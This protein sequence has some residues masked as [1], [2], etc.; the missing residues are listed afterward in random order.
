MLSQP[1]QVT[2]AVLTIKCVIEVFREYCRGGSHSR[3]FGASADQVLLVGAVFVG[4]AE[5]RPMNASKLSEYVGMPRATVIRKLGSLSRR[6]VIERDGGG[7]VL[8][9]ETLL[10]ER[11]KDAMVRA[12]KCLVD[13]AAKLSRLDTLAIACLIL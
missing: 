3:R 8:S 10:N 2:E 13:T 9:K 12:R 11:S 4:Q 7:Y 1:K 6:G 5:G